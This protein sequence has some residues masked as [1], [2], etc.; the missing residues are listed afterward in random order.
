MIN[1]MFSL[2]RFVKYIN[3]NL[4]MSQIPSK[5]VNIHDSRYPHLEDQFSLDYFQ[6]IIHFLKQEKEEGK[7]IYPAGSHIF[8]AFDLTHRDDIKVVILGQD[9]YHSYGQAHG[10]CFSVPNG[11]AAPPSLQNIFKE[12]KSEYPASSASISNLEGTENDEW[13]YFRKQATDL[14]PRANQWVLLLNAFLTVEECKPLSHSK[15]WREIFTDQVIKTI[16]EQKT[17]IVFMLRGGFAKSKMN[18]INNQKHLVLTA[19]HPSPLSANRWGW[20]GCNHFKL[21][22]EYIQKHWEQ[23]I[24]WSL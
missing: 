11:I 3:Y 16:S 4:T 17:G 15:I 13:N 9:P 20:F 5:L 1:Y 12:I 24:F 18:L 10:L 22:N 7:I 19:N 8:R 14:T 6:H 2:S 21:C 23:G